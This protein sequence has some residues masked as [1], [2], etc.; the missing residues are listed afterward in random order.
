MVRRIYISEEQLSI[1]ADA[2]DKEVTYYEFLLSAKKFLKELLINPGKAQIDG[3]LSSN[4]MNKDEFIQKMKDL[5]LIKSSEKIDEV[6]IEGT[7]KK[8]AKHFIQYKVPRSR[9]KEKMKELYKECFPSTENINE[10]GAT[11]CGSVMQG[12]GT[13]PD[14]GQFTVPFGGV[15]RRKFYEPTLKR[16]KDEKNGSIS[17]NHD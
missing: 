16:N 12:G 2:Q 14:A 8:V 10:D 5:G 11:S 15:Q 3:L 17:I 9:F 1:L 13:N 4:G 7:D 6:Q